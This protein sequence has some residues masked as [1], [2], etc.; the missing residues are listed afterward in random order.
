MKEKKK[1]VD[2]EI[3]QNEKKFKENIY[4]YRVNEDVYSAYADLSDGY[5]ISVMSAPDMS[6]KYARTF[7]ID[8]LQKSVIKYF[9]NKSKK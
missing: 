6:R 2:A 1:I 5:R 3:A 9:A 8:E 7:C 4:F